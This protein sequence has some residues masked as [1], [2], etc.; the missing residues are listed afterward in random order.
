MLLAVVMFDTINALNPVLIIGSI[1]STF[2]HYAGIV[3][4][5]MIPLGMVMGITIVGAIFDDPLLKLPVKAIG[6]YLF[7]LDACLLGRFFYKN[8]EKL[9]WDV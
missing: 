8:E 7:M 2:L 5:F 9:R 1:F 4:L 6:L 3:L